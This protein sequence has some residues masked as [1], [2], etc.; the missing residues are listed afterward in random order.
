[1]TKQIS[2]FA[3]D[4]DQR[5]LRFID[6]R[7]VRVRVYEDG[8]GEP[9]VLIH[10]GEFG[11]VNTLDEWSLN[12]KALAKHFHVY[13][14]DKPGQGYSD[15]PKRD[16]DYT[17]EW[18]FQSIHDVFQ[19]LGVRQ[20]HWAGHSRGALVV[21]RMALDH[22]DLVKSAILVDS[23]TTAPEDPH[24]PTYLFYEEID[25][26][27]PPGPPTLATVRVEADAQC[28]SKAHIT[29]DFV[30][31]LLKIA[32]LPA[33][34]EAQQRMQDL[35]FTVWHPSLYRVRKQ[36][37]AE[38]S[39]RG[40]P[41]PTLVIWGFNDRGAPLYLGHRLFE[42]ICPTTPHAEFHVF[43]QAGHYCFREQW[44]KFNRAVVNFCL[45]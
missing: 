45:S 1:M 33:V 34:Q 39:E 6:A 4:L 20:A 27:T 3:D 31:R 11:S 16:A 21:A 44:Q 40:L 38:I 9:L 12:L 7:G 13:A 28:F 18:L 5:K 2:S 37:V 26:R 8:A 24:V 23:S 14:I 43:N 32:E 30:G 35:R 36:T 17:F 42:R 29:D 15:I 41:V 25:A 19:V 22:P 10:G